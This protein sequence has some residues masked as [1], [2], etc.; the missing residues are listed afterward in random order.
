MTERIKMQ[1][2]SR[3]TASFESALKTAKEKLNKYEEISFS[4]YNDFKLGIITKEEYMS[5]KA[6]LPQLQVALKK[7]ITEL[8]N[9]IDAYKNARETKFGL[10]N[11]EEYLGLKKLNRE[12]LLELVDKI[13][14]HEDNGISIDFTFKNEFEMAKEYLESEEGA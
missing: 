5:Y 11:L 7:E 14:I 6:K 8:E 12:I 9:K 3:N 10:E 1:P 13:Y 2:K 4:L